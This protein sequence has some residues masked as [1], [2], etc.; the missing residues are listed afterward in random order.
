MT[1]REKRVRRRAAICAVLTMAALMTAS[2]GAQARTVQLGSPLTAKFTPAHFA[3]LTCCI[4]GGGSLTLTP[5][6]L[7]QTALPESGVNVTSPVDGTVISYRLAAADGMFGIQVLRLS[8]TPPVPPTFRSQRGQ[9]VATS[10]PT[11][12]TA[13]GVSRPIVTHLALKKGDSVGI[14]NFPDDFFSDRIGSTKVVGDNWIGHGSSGGFYPED[15]LINFW[16]PPLV[17]GAPLS[18]SGEM[19]AEL[20]LQAT[21][22]YCKVPKLKGKSPKGARKTLTKADCRVG[23]LKKTNK[24]RDR[25]EVVSQSVK[26][27]TAISDT[28]PINLKVS[29]QQG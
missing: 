5:V 27:G 14:R 28:Q 26:P 24:V 9:S 17:D 21:V 8:P 10:A 18:D 22:R 3:S 2:S 20:G 29:R 25:K 13:S 12:I 1:R 23:K 7:V 19:A 11:P 16:Y 6:T 4:F 15:G